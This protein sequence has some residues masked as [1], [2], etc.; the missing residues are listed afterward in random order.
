M[1]YKPKPKMKMYKGSRMVEEVINQIKEKYRFIDLLKPETGAV[2]PILL[3]LEP[4]YRKNISKILSIYWQLNTK[5]YTDSIK[6]L[7]ASRSLGLPEDREVSEEELGDRL[8]EQ[9]LTKMLKEDAE[10]EA[11]KESAG[12]EQEMNITEKGNLP[13]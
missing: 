8:I 12:I 3:A 10:V 9:E 13:R 5:Q 11:F 7:V 2:M 1:T 4:S 6:A